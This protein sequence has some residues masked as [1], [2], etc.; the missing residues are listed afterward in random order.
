MTTP[1]VNERAA[2][3]DGEIYEAPPA[4]A[5]QSADASARP[6]WAR[7]A[8][9]AALG[10]ALWLLLLTLGVPWVFHIGGLDGLVPA[11]A[12]GAVLGG[13]RW[14]AVL[15]AVVL[16]L[17]LVVLVVASTPIIVGP[18]Q[19]FIRNDPLPAHAD[20]IVVLSAGVND[21]GMMLPQATDRLL[22]GIELLNRG[23]APV[24]VLGE[25]SYLEDGHLVSSRADHNRIV[26]LSPGALS[27]VVVSG[28][29]LS[30]HDE[31]I[32][33]A[34]LF[35]ARGW[36]RVVV[37]TS[38]IHTRRACATFEHAGVVVS[39]AASDSRS[40]AVHSLRVPGDRIYA[41]QG[42]LYEVAGT[43]RYRQLGW[44]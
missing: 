1:I 33:A 12:L 28:V 34:A 30:T 2:S 17:S 27:K 25:E 38:P 14:N 22:K 9:G 18:A 8:N 42:W 10:V 39:C 13:T 36:K 37:V 35:R 4:V 26:S 20:A 41:F 6:A 44:L 5:T 21:D 3:R 23:I 16:V 32:R 24:L 29:T 15:L 31:A 19:S 7:V 11:I 43:L 40:I